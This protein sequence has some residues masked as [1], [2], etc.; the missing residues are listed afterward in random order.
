MNFRDFD[1]T[2]CIYWVQVHGLPLQFINKDNAMKI[3]GLFKEVIRCEHSSQKNVLG[4]KFMRMQVEVD[5]SRPL[6]TGF[7]PKFEEGISWIQ[8]RYERLEDLYYK[9]GVLGHLK[10]NCPDPLPRLSEEEG[11]EFGSWLRAEDGTFTVVSKGN[12]LQ[13]VE[14]S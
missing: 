8:F 5:I 14:N 1:F 9:C 12:F 7:F 2:C 13:R 3:S 4:M 10:R 6:P 11:H